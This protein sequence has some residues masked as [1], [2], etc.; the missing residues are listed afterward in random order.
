MIRLNRWSN[1]IVNNRHVSNFTSLSNQLNNL[2]QHSK[3]V[4]QIKY[5]KGLFGH[6]VLADFNGFYIFRQNA[7]TRAQSLVNEATSDKRNRKMVHIFDELSNS[8]CKVA[9]LAEFIRIA[10]PDRN[11]TNAAEQASIEINAEVERLNTNRILYNSLSNVVQNGDIVPTTPTDDYVTKLFLFDFEQCGIHLDENVR[12]EVVRLN[13][14][15][16]HVGTYFMYGTTKPRIVFKKEIPEHLWKYFPIDNNKIVISGLQNESNDAQLR[17][18]SFK[19]F[20][21]YDDHQE[22]LLM[23]LICSRLKLAKICGFNSFAHR[24]ING[25]I[26]GSPEIVWNLIDTVNT[27][28]RHK[29]EAD[30]NYMLKLKSEET[31]DPSAQL[32]QWDV[33]YYTQNHKIKKFGHDITQSSPYFSIGSCMEGLDLI[34]QSIFNVELKISD[35]TQE[36][37]W[38]PSVIKL[39]VNDQKT[40]KTLGHIYCDFFVRPNKPYN[41]CH[42]TIQGGCD[43]PNGKL[44]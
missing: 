6:Q 1:F 29:S 37:L 20:L 31:G 24:A 23:E 26:A 12:N 35:T 36:D 30:F 22:Q 41:D 33:P 28:I 40:S 18:I 16:L 11:Y 10:H 13:E 42:F 3:V 19:Q 27:I 21:Q 44:I 8:L 25:S 15:I 38:H 43:L 34:F 39:A 2:T 7:I 14:H 4:P 17:E 5:H 9:D 32:M